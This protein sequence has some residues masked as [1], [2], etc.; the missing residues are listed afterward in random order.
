MIHVAKAAP[1]VSKSRHGVLIVRSTVHDGEKQYVY[2]VPPVNGPH[3]HRHRESTALPL[4]VS[5]D[6]A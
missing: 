2:W 3:G 5:T 4:P 6:L 1:V